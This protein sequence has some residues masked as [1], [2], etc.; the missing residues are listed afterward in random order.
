MP[1][2]RYRSF[3]REKRKIVFHSEIHCNNLWVRNWNSERAA[4]TTYSAFL[5]SGLIRWQIGDFANIGILSR[6]TVMCETDIPKLPLN[7]W[8]VNSIPCRVH[9][10]KLVMRNN[11]ED[12][13][14]SSNA[15]AGSISIRGRKLYNA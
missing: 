15:E 5:R 6:I 14:R 10:P 1:G 2:R 3:E 4:T 7:N 8:Q 12:G 11:V 9:G 13:S